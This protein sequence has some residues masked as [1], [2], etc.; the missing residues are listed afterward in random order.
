MFVISIAMDENQGIGYKGALPWH[1]KE[2]L[3][4]FKENTLHQTLLMGQ[5][6][7]DG[8]PRKLVDRKIVVCSSD[9]NY[10]VEDEDACVIYDLEAFLKEHEN[11]EETIIVCGGASIYRQAYPY[12][13]KALISF[14]KGEY[15]V[16]TY[17]DIFKLEDWDIT[18][19]VEYEDF[20]YR[21]MKR[22]EDC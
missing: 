9:S 10:K 16:D 19:E 12:C 14:V 3:K 18:K 6:T 2:E 20:I 5:T 4:L 22:K 8:L 7:Y 21:E 13:K 1:L 15:E 17:F 11:T